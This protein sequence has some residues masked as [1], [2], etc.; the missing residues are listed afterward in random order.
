M[1][2]S[3]REE[4]EREPGRLRK[5]LLALI[6]ITIAGL[7]TELALMEHVESGWQ[8]A[9]L[10]ALGVGLLATILVVGRPSAAAFTFF[11]LV[12]ASYLLVGAIGV[13]L[14][15]NANAE[16]EL[17]LDPDAGGAELLWIAL[18][19]GVPAGA[20]GAMA[21]LGLLGLV[22]AHRHPYAG[23]RRNDPAAG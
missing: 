19:G 21:Q 8:Q 22:F 3:E 13:Y 16:L 2:K 9:P 7:T 1:M 23:R 12:M 11:R 18:R 4:L 10:I 15:V 14:H 6:L 17:E 5:L 20:P